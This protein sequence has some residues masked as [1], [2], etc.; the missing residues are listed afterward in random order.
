MASNWSNATSL[1]IGSSFVLM[2]K[3]ENTPVILFIEI[4]K[5]NTFI[6]LRFIEQI[7]QD[8]TNKQDN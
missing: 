7:L 6:T 8:T 4:R 5:R 1:G 3:F 2:C